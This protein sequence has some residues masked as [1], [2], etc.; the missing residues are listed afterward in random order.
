MCVIGVRIA[1]EPYPGRDERVEAEW[2]KAEKSSFKSFSANAVCHLLLNWLFQLAHSGACWRQ[3][4]K[5][6]GGRRFGPATYRPL[7]I[8]TG[9]EVLLPMTATAGAR[10]RAP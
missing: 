9:G 4:W 6:D 8:S 5:C 2:S 1:S 7:R 3:V 10:R